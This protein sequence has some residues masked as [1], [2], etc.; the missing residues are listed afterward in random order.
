ML[1]IYLGIPIKDFIISTTVG[2]LNNNL[3][4]GNLFEKHIFPKST[5]FKI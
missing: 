2:I 1:I 4:L 5:Y 3:I